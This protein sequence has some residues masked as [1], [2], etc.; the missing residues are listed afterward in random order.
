M[1]YEAFKN[2]NRFGDRDYKEQ[3]CHFSGKKSNGK[4]T[5]NKPILSEY[6]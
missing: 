4:T 6:W 2:W 1:S 3:Y 5:T